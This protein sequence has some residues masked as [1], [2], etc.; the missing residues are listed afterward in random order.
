MPEQAYCDACIHCFFKVQTNQ[1]SGEYVRGAKYAA[2]FRQ[3]ILQALE[4]KY[5]QGFPRGWCVEL[6]QRIPNLALLCFETEEAL[7]HFFS[8]LLSGEFN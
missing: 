4:E 8:T 3:R 6:A 2:E 7:R 1:L 5:L